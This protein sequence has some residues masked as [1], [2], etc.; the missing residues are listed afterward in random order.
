MMYL[1]CE[2]CIY[3]CQSIFS[4]SAFFSRFPDGMPVWSNQSVSVRIWRVSSAIYSI[5]IFAILDAVEPL[6]HIK[7]I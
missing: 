5:I 1:P 7:C 6:S 2:N 3:H 4:A